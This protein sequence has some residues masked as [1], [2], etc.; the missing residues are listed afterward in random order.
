MAFEFVNLMD[1][2][3]RRRSRV[4]APS[5]APFNATKKGCRNAA[6]LLF[7]T[8]FSSHADFAGSAA[9]ET[10]AIAPALRY[11]TGESGPPCGGREMGYHA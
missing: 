10:L 1:A 11:Q 4:R 3:S 9:F 2:L 5:L 7:R 8:L 6:L